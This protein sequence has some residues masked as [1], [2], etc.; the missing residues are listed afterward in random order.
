MADNKHS[1]D[2]GTTTAATLSAR[3]A[4]SVAIADSVAAQNAKTALSKENGALPRV[5]T[6]SSTAARAPRN[7]SSSSTSARSSVYEAFRGTETGKTPFSLPTNDL[8]A[9]TFLAH[10]YEQLMKDSANIHSEGASQQMV[11]PPPLP[12]SGTLPA[13]TAPSALGRILMNHALDEPQTYVF[14]FTN[15]RSGNQ[16]GRSLM[17]MALRNFRLRDRPEVQVQVYDVTDKESQ[18]EGLHYLHQLQLRQGDRLLKTAFP[19]LFVDFS[20]GKQRV[21]PS[22]RMFSGNH[23]ELFPQPNEVLTADSGQQESTTNSSN[24]HTNSDAWEE[25]ITEAA[26]QL[27]S[28]LDRF[29]E[30][31]ITK[32]LEQ[33]QESAIKLHVWSAGG[34]GT[35]SSTLEAMMEYGIDVGRL[36]F[37]CIPF[38]TGNDFADALG[39]GRS[40]P[41][42]AVGESMRLLNKIISERL[43][44]Y[45]CKLDIYEITFTTYDDGHIKHVEKN[46]FEKP[47][48]R[49]HKCL[50]ID[51]FSLGVQGFVGS[52]FELHRPGKRALNILMYTVAAA[53]WVFL[54]KFPPI[55][56][57]LESIS[58]V[59][60][61]IMN[62]PKMT[63]VDRVRWL[64]TASE[65]ERRQVLLSR[66]AGPRKRSGGRKMTWTKEPKAR[67][68]ATARDF[69]EGVDKDVPVIQSK[70]IELDVQNVARFWGRNIDVWNNADEAS[71]RRILSNTTGV[72]DRNTWTPQYAGDGKLELFGVRNIGDY[73]L[74]QLPGRSTYRIDRLAQMGS[75]VV[76]HFRHPQ[77]YPPRSRNPLTDHK[78]IEQ[79]LLYSM[80]DG[81]FI[82]MY[83]PRDVIISRK[84]TL[85]AVGRS[86]ESSRIVLDTIKNDGLDAVQMDATAAASKTRTGEP[87]GV[88]N[89]VSSPFMRIF[90]FG[91]NAR[92]NTIDGS[93]GTAD[94]LANVHIGGY[95]TGSVL[96][97]RSPART[98][99]DTSNN[100]GDLTRGLS[101]TSSSRRSVF[102]SL[103]DS[104]FR[105]VGRSRPRSSS[106]K[107]SSSR[108]SN[109]S[110][111]NSSISAADS[112]GVEND[113]NKTQPPMTKPSY[114]HLSTVHEQSPLRVRQ[115]LSDLRQDSNSPPKVD[116]FDKSQDLQSLT[117]PKA[118]N[119]AHV[120][121]SKSLDIRKSSPHDGIADML[122]TANKA[123]SGGNKHPEMQQSP[124]YSS[125][126][127]STASA[128]GEEGD[129][130]VTS[131]S[132]ISESSCESRTVPNTIGSKASCTKDN[133]TCAQE[134][135]RPLSL[136]HCLLTLGK[137]LV[138][139]IEVFT[140][141]DALM[142]PNST[143]D[144]RRP[145]NFG[146]SP[147]P[148]AQN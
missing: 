23:E 66:V 31:E 106:V 35:V 145:S 51:Y 67:R 37:S 30:D 33:A 127:N 57:A 24:S 72:T 130:D 132:G 92:T 81:E 21:R 97:V 11:T 8:T 56:E 129:L 2:T 100:G 131:T 91:R 146:H 119:P 138:D 133:Q 140:S 80:C 42:D 121:R 94:K 26:S 76:L 44:G 19:E 15:P 114:S 84:V 89:Y 120:A 55:N 22:P 125:S 17:D 32:R 123:D 108:G 99:S 45:T 98:D 38:G 90:R 27:Q 59:P 54:K 53:K 77:D 107:N 111:S 14:I 148:A 87:V 118:T 142:P 65:A 112:N 136:Q 71:A 144:N 113:A 75:P 135:L 88:S 85:K 143:L 96:E 18:R 101:Y 141:P 115:S 64:E 86:P 58:T 25:W 4:K 122:L 79:G 43:D 36:Y 134:P 34:D 116:G 16:Q 83:H 40:V 93:F 82:E 52:S 104:F 117:V 6:F 95:A 3:P 124:S 50:M 20:C 10:C 102:S 70:P 5:K 103:R 109:S 73:A 39:W 126:T 63:D 9:A 137:D 49:R 1:G 47:G 139:S 41:G 110:S 28:G 147:S 62:D 128:A 68:T 78:T 7:I 13:G 61:H 60:D 74:N 105:S 69:G 48:M 29:T 46:M 12:S